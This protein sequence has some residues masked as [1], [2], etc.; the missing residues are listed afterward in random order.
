MLRLT[1]VI[2]IY[3]IWIYLIYNLIRILWHTEA[4]NLWQLRCKKGVSDLAIPHPDPSCGSRCCTQWAAMEDFI[5]ETPEGWMKG[6]F[7]SGKKS[8]HR[9]AFTW[10]V[11]MSFVV[12]IYRICIES[13]YSYICCVIFCGASQDH[14]REPVCCV[15]RTS[16]LMKRTRFW[17]PAIA[18]WWTFLQKKCFFGDGELFGYSLADIFCQFQTYPQSFSAKRLSSLLAEWLF[19]SPQG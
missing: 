2:C 11:F 8:W 4:F 10:I 15:F 18:P 9:G 12:L 13:S 16:E 1:F 7:F 14:P 6:V 17:G 3:N 5:S 19:S